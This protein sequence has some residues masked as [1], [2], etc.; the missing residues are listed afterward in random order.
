MNLRD[1]LLTSIPSP[2]G[3]HLSGDRI[4]F[5]RT[6]ALYETTLPSLGTQPLTQKQ[7]CAP[8]KKV[9]LGYVVG[10]FIAEVPRLFVS[11]HAPRANPRLPT[12]PYAYVSPM[13]GETA[14]Q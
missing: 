2:S 4:P 5:F 6:L 14:P 3:L 8:L 10:G 1:A 9:L 11:S 7:L 13:Q 12:P